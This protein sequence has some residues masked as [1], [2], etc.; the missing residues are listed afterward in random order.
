[1]TYKYR[2]C[3][4][5]RREWPAKHS[6]CPNC[7]RWLGDRPLERTE[8]NVGP[9]AR[10]TFA[11]AR[12]ELIGGTAIR[13]R[14][15]V[16]SPLHDILAMIA[17]P[18][19]QALGADDHRSTRA[20]PGHGWLVW[21]TVGLRR[22][23]L[24]GLDIEERLTTTLRRLEGALHGSG[25]FRWGAWVDQYII[26]V[27]ESGAPEISEL[28]ASAIFDFE[29]DNLLLCSEGLYN[30]N[31]SWEHFVCV[32]RRLLADGERSGYRLLGH[33]HPS[34]LDH[35]KT[36]D[37]APFVGRDEELAFLT[38]C[39]E[40]SRIGMSRAALIADAGSGKTRLVREWRR[41]HPTL[42]M[43][44][45]NFSLFGGDL[46]SFTSQLAVVPPERIGIAD[47]VGAVLAR[48]EAETIEVLVLDDLHWAN[49]E[50]VTFI[51]RL[52]DALVTRNI[53]VLLVTRPS[54]RSVLAAL[55]PAEE[56]ALRPLPLSATR[57]LARR[58]IASQRLAALAT[59]L[60]KGNPLFIEQFSAW[61]KETAYQKTDKAPQNL[62][63]VIAA[64]ITHL[65]KVRLFDIRQ[66]LRWGGLWDRQTIQQELDGLEG[67]I[68]LW[69]DRLETGD[70]G[71]RIEV[72]RHLISLERLDFEIFLAGT[73]AGKPRPRSS[74]L[75]EAIERLL[76]GSAPQ[77]LAD[78][79]S[80]AKYANDAQKANILIE[81][82]HAAN[83]TAGRYDWC[84]AAQFYELVQTLAEPR[85]REESAYRLAECRER[86]SGAPIEIRTAA[87]TPWTERSPA[88]D[89]LRLPAAWAQ[90]GQRYGTAAYFGR[91]AEA[92]AA[93]NDHAFAEW[94]RQRELQLKKA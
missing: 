42:H 47:L 75:R 40:K 86:C 52:L 22:A 70:Y 46:I 14:I 62:H 45:A 1:M 81:A 24:Q 10:E 28:T 34:A 91:A 82:Q 18:L 15:L 38:A 33:K 49:S 35:A 39:Y 12:Y 56:L 32:P 85:Q 3:P 72:S 94:A 54:G 48:I 61:A 67:E 64:R 88:I 55:K 68:G 73:L 77:I 89:D 50:G 66:R 20:V 78:L 63:Q 84:L 6:S 5:C 7:V 71:D 44:V 8:W 79:E 4:S 25:R 30:A 21:T 90:L 53:L 92:A 59:R 23:F 76:V 17:D 13:L 69:L 26:P 2:Y 19:K 37:V 93:I 29:P 58:M 41:Q 74:R 57:D 16:D 80:R 9:A 87:E 51:E 36:P 60:S 65:S 83:S 43:L 27:G 11:C 31:R